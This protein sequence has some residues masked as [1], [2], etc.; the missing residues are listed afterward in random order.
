MARCEATTR[1]GTRCRNPAME[2]S[3]YCNVHA[4]QAEREDASTA[5]GDADPLA[6][7]SDAARAVIGAAVLGAIVL[8]ALKLGRRF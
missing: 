2:G 7:L 3:R 6:E 5:P 4:E 8:V 1:K